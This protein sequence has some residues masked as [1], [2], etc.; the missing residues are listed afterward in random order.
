MPF[1]GASC[2][3][4]HNIGVGCVTL[5]LSKRE[6]K[7]SAPVPRLELPEGMSKYCVRAHLVPTCK[8][9]FGKGKPRE[10][11]LDPFFTSLA[12]IIIWGGKQSTKLEIIGSTQNN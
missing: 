6:K 3:K 1:I 2:S 8:E 4:K 11:A 9:L 12:I 10:R 5:Q 7:N